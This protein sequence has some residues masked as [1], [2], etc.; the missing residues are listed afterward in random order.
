MGLFRLLAR[1]TIG[2]LFVGHGTQKLFGWFGGG[3]LEGTA[4]FFE[5]LGFRPGRR[6]AL[7]AGAAEA[8]GGLLF[9]LGAATPLGAAAVSGSMITAIKTV[10]WEGRLGERGWL[11]VQPRS[12][13]RG[14][15]PDRERTG[16]VV[17]RRRVGEKPLGDRLG[18]RGSQCRSGRLGSSA[19]RGRTRGGEG[20][21]APCGRPRARYR[22]LVADA[23][24]ARN[25]RTT[26][27]A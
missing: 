12:A 17:G 8:G 18:A 20:G 19:L 4:G 27:R 10:H 2:L 5:Q 6:Y 3:G 16:Q 22:C 1:T 14:L 11:R 7:A 25:H 21:G 23:G 24:S 15:R 26:N 9:A 13:R